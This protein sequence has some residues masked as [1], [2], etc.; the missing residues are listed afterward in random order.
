MIKLLKLGFNPDGDRI[1]PTPLATAE[2]L[3]AAKATPLDQAFIPEATNDIVKQE[4]KGAVKLTTK[5][6]NMNVHAVKLNKQIR[7]TVASNKRVAKRR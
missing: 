1:I 4:I 6:E 2:N 3:R 5:Q 7:K